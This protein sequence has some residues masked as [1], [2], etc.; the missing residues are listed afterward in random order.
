MGAS[1]I[2]PDVAAA[3]KRC[4]PNGVLD[5]FETSESYF[6]EIHP[7]LGIPLRIFGQDPGANRHR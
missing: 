7:A 2:P 6:H 5:E 1:Q 3:I 4:W